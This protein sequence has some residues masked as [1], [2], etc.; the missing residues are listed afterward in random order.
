MKTLHTFLVAKGQTIQTDFFTFNNGFHMPV[1][2]TIDSLDSLVE[3]QAKK[4][5]E[6]EKEIEEMTAE[7]CH[8]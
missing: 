3:R 7:A 6:L 4:I 2:V 5:M 1:N 8:A